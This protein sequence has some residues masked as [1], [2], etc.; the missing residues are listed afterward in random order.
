[1]LG[2]RPA[3]EDVVQDAFLGLY[4]RW[5][6]LRDTASAPGYL[7]A[8]VL[9]GC[10][11]A[12]RSRTQRNDSAAVGELPW[13]P[14]GPGRRR[15][16]AAMLD[17]Q[18]GYAD[19]ASATGAD[20]IAEILFNAQP[21]VRRPCARRRAGLAVLLPGVLRLRRPHGG[22]HPRRGRGAPARRRGV[23]A[24]TA[25]PAVCFRGLLPPS[26]LLTRT[27]RT[28]LLSAARQAV[29]GARPQVK[30]TR[31]NGSPGARRAVSRRRQQGFKR[32]K[33]DLRA[34]ARPSR[35]PLRDLHAAARRLAEG[36]LADLLARDVEVPPPQRQRRRHLGGDRDRGDPVGREKPARDPTSAG[37]R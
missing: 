4:K 9:N 3:A 6:H 13:D 32:G 17:R 12:L 30:G 1:M 34:S 27:M 20:G 28:P 19:V 18:P 15:L 16:V 7:R 21:L 33:A 5:K 10:R 29:P 8:S 35:Q 22:P 37:R 14:R 23:T 31:A 36:E 11:V 2:D 25:D 24:G 26:P